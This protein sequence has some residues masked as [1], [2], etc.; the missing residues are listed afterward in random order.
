MKK[1]AK[2]RKKDEKRG[3][4]INKN[5]DKKI[6]NHFWAPCEYSKRKVLQQF[7][8]QMFKNSMEIKLI[9]ANVRSHKKKVYRGLLTSLLVGLE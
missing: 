1:G 9:A 3:E 6:G 7:L 8:W 2:R 5:V 4:K